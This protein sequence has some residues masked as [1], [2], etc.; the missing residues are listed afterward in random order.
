MTYKEYDR[1]KNNDEKK[2]I[3]EK[4]K[5]FLNWYNEKLENGYHPYLDLKG[6]Q[7]LIDYMVSLYEFKYCDSYFEKQRGCINVRDFIDL[8]EISDLINFDQIRYR[9]THKELEVLDCNY[10]SNSGFCRPT[11]N[12]DGSFNH[13]KY[14]FF[15][16]F[17]LK[18]KNNFK[19]IMG[20]RVSC[21]ENGMVPQYELELLE[22]YIG[23]TYNNMDIQ[24]LLHI[25]EI[26]DK[27]DVT[28]LKKI[29]CTHK[30]DLE[31]RNKIFE[32]ILYA[33]LYSEE[34]IPEHGLLRAQKFAKEI[35]E[36]YYLNFNCDNLKLLIEEAKKVEE[37]NINN[38]SEDV[39]TEKQSFVKKIIKKITVK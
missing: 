30:I 19:K 29:I 26:N 22:E 27:L 38:D 3:V 7:H 32:M 21:L 28:E 6:L 37:K 36:Y 14:D 39:I 20:H 34:T 31:L 9:L 33:M 25:L 10:R 24:K 2:Y 35:N 15:I 17:E 23:K 8:E 18:E 11:Y 5:E 1:F 13:K 16:G 4:N 12:E